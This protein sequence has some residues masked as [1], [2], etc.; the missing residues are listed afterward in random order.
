M[1]PYLKP[2]KSASEQLSDLLSKPNAF[3]I[4]AYPHLVLMRLPFAQRIEAMRR[5]LMPPRLGP[6]KRMAKAAGAHDHQ[7]QVEARIHDEANY[8]VLSE[9]NPL[10]L[11]VELLAE[12]LEEVVGSGVI[13]GVMSDDGELS[14]SNLLAAMVVS[15]IGAAGESMAHVLD[16]AIHPGDPHFNPW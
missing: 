14:S 5:Q 3:L 7:G 16:A 12:A 10:V 8:R 1:R 13:D 15:E 2:V 4:E 11:G 9:L 6:R